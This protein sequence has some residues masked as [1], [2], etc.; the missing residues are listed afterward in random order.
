MHLAAYI[1]AFSAFSDFG[2]TNG[3]LH[4]VNRSRGRNRS[5]KRVRVVLLHSGQA[6][7]TRHFR[8]GRV[9]DNRFAG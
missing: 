2:L 5:P 9:I 6:D 7:H 8:F 4:L 3:Y 1:T